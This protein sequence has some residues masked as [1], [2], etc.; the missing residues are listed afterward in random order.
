M[1]VTRRLLPPSLIS[2][3][4]DP[5]GGDKGEGLGC[6]EDPPRPARAA[7]K[8][9]HIGP[10]ISG[11]KKCREMRPCPGTKCWS[12]GGGRRRLDPAT[13]G[14]RQAGEGKRGHFGVV[15]RLRC[16]CLALRLDMSTADGHI[17]P[18]RRKQSPKK[19]SKTERDWARRPRQIHGWSAP[20]VRVKRPGH[21]TQH[22]S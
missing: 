16:S 4:G 14:G 20:Q 22:T 7:P 18:K 3:L 15:Y 19:M 21:E 5:G 1:W 9:G 2:S 12:Q 8:L 11:P 13:C 10:Q 17:L 6:M